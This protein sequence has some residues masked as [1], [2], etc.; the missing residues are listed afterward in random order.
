MLGKEELGF[1]LGMNII[2]MD[3]LEEIDNRIRI[4]DKTLLSIKLKNLRE[5]RQ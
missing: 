5:R 1:K 2:Y 4:E 3:E